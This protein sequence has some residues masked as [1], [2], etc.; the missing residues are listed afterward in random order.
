MM[1]VVGKKKKEEK[2]TGSQKLTRK[3]KNHG[4]TPGT[5]D[6]HKQRTVPSISY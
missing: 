3:L 4:M 6:I 1:V 5:S 2:C